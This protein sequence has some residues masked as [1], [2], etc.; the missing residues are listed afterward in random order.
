M[1][2]MPRKGPYTIGRESSPASSMPLTASD[3][4]NFNVEGG[5]KEGRAGGRE[6]KREK[7]AKSK[8]KICEK[9]ILFCAPVSALAFRRAV[10][11]VASPAIHDNPRASPREGTAL[12]TVECRNLK[13]SNGGEKI[14]S[15]CVV[16]VGEY[17]YCLGKR[18]NNFKWE[19]VGETEI[20]RGNLS[21][22]F[23]NTIE[24]QYDMSKSRLLRFDLFGSSS[25]TMLANED[26]DHHIGVYVCDVNDL[27]KSP[28]YMLEGS[29]VVTRRTQTEKHLH[30]QFEATKSIRATLNISHLQ[31]AFQGSDFDNSCFLGKAEF[32]HALQL[33]ARQ[34]G[35]QMDRK[36][37]DLLW[38]L[39]EE[40]GNGVINYK[41]FIGLVYGTQGYISVMVED[42]NI[43]SADKHADLLFS[44][45]QRDLNKVLGRQNKVGVSE[46]DF[47][48]QKYFK[49]MLSETQNRAMRFVRAARVPTEYR[50][51]E[52]QHTLREQTGILQMSDKNLLV[53]SRPAR[54]PMEW[55]RRSKGLGIILTKGNG[56]AVATCNLLHENAGPCSVRS[57]QPIPNTGITYFELSIGRDPP[58]QPGE[59][60]GGSY[61]VGLATSALENFDGAWTHPVINT[62]CY[63]LVSSMPTKYEA[64]WSL[65]NKSPYILVHGPNNDLATFNEE[66]VIE[67]I[68]RGDLKRTDIISNIRA[69]RPLPRGTCYFEITIKSAGFGNGESLGGDCHVGLCSEKMLGWTGDWTKSD[70]NRRE[71]AWTLCDNWNGQLSMPVFGNT[72]DKLSEKQMMQ[73]MQKQFQLFDQDNSGTLDWEELHLALKEMSISCTDDE[74]RDMFLALGLKQ[75]EEIHFEEYVSII[76]SKAATGIIFHVEKKHWNL[77]S[78]FGVGDTIGFQVDTIKGVAQIFKNKK[79]LGQGF[80]D[81]PSVI[82]PFVS[83][84]NVGKSAV[85]TS[86]TSKCIDSK[87]ERFIAGYRKLWVDGSGFGAADRIG[88]LV[89][90]DA[91][92]CDIYKNGAYL[93]RAFERLP[94]NLHPFATLCHTGS[95]ASLCLPPQPNP[96]YYEY[97]K[98]NLEKSKYFVIGDI[99][100]AGGRIDL[101]ET[102]TSCGI[103][104]KVLEGGEHQRG[105][106]R[107]LLRAC[108]IER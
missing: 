57:T 29:L 10:V 5:R 14:D 20:A 2:L 51:R 55:D 45:Y 18:K 88:F 83:L 44:K 71:E 38:S 31:T 76:R 40:D 33:M 64:R 22:Q 36:T 107:F 106:R 80:T 62:A 8:V 99:P 73:M 85:I 108:D 26:E 50:G 69:H 59:G 37:E 60:L 103:Q 42:Q 78:F 32:K 3:Y 13:W 47:D 67:R 82:Y 53:D 35:F 15:K 102:G 25:V 79:W 101:S 75:D 28:N 74:V 96:W 4:K 54:D 89:N 72:A 9:Q 77:N 98:S 39:S 19:V 68:A 52:E 6:G 93:G 24:I 91:K 100:C 84:P 95:K 11:M 87:S 12:V 63:A 58:V 23:E 30:L 49:K 46:D 65:R 92:A 56:I 105:D 86:D 90:M 43:R 17:E 34:G 66:S 7:E 61:A 81:L 1:Q 104:L 27:L 70:D 48:D 16:S 41:E 94:P 97:M 21:P